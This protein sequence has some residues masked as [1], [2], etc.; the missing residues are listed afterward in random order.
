MA[1]EELTDGA[2]HAA[3]SDGRV[4]VLERS[5]RRWSLALA[6]LAVLLPGALYGLF[7]RQARRL[8]ALADHGQLAEATVTARREGST[9][10]T[11]V[12]EGTR[13]TWSVRDGEA[14]YA[15][16]E[17]LAITYLPELPSFSRPGSNRSVAAAEAAANR[18]FAGKMVVGLFWF[19]AANVL[20]HQVRLRRLRA[21]GR[22]EVDDPRGHR[23]RLILTGV[24]LVAPMLALVFGWHATDA[25]DRSET[26]WPV[27]LGAVV[28]LGVLGGTLFY[29]LRHGVA[30]ASRRAA[31]VLTW[32]LPLV[33]AV[34]VVRA[35]A[36]IVGR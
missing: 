7:H 30:H 35:L 19:F 23:T 13:H 34:A 3:T 31:R 20:V 10:Y 2:H 22:T 26:S 16:G 17:T 33:M 18:S 15:V 12:V 9:F 11:Y 6:L 4:E 8:D 27:V 25:R 28:A 24:L 32:A 14:P 1:D 36:W 5:L 29:V 21:T